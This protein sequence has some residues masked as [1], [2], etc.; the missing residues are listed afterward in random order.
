[1]AVCN[2]GRDDGIKHV[3]KQHSPI[4]TS[5]GLYICMF[6]FVLYAIIPD[7]IAYCHATRTVFEY[8]L[9]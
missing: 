4:P 8:F 1:M 2:K 9:V 3:V 6:N 7:F 5:W